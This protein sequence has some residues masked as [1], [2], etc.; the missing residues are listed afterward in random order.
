MFVLSF[1]LTLVF[2]KQGGKIDAELHIADAETGLI[3]VLR[4]IYPRDTFKHDCG[5]R[6]CDLINAMITGFIKRFC[7]DRAD[8][9]YPYKIAQNS[10]P[11]QPAQFSK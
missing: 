3:V 10:S 5:V 1:A 4:F 7:R 11:E 9:V 8:A 6:L 2:D